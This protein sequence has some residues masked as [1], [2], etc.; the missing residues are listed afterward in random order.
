MVD[1]YA[2]R[3][4]HIEDSEQMSLPDAEITTIPLFKSI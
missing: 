4:E 2:F 3:A 1:Y